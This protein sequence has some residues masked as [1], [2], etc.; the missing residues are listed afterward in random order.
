MRFLGQSGE[1]ELY[2]LDRDPNE[3][4]NRVDHPDYSSTLAQLKRQLEDWER[5]YPPRS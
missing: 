1:T 5:R 3:L 4:E 2:D